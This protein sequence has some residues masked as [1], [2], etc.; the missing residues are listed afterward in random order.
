[1]KVQVENLSPI[2]RKL[3]IEV[4]PSRVEA[5]LDRA[6]QSLSREVKIAGFRPGKVPRRILEQRFRE[7]VEDDVIRR[8]VEGAFLEAIEK[9]EVPAVGAPQVKPA[10]LKPNEP[11]TFEARVEVRP[12]V[13]A[14]DYKGLLL[15][16]RPLEVPDAQVDE[17]L[18]QMR[19]S[20]SR[21]EPVE[22]RQ[23]AQSGDFVVV[24][25]SATVDGT[26]FAGSTGTDVTMEVTQGELIQANVAAL[27]GVKLGEKKVVDYAF[28]ADYRLDEVKGKTARFEFLLKGLKHKVVPALNDELAKEVGGVETLDALR[29][30]VR[31]EIERSVKNKAANETREELFHK[32][33]EKNPLEVPKAM[34][35]DALNFMLEG[36]LRALAR[37][38]LDPRRLGIDFNRLRDEMRPKAELEVKGTLLADSVANAEG[39]QAGDEDFEK[40]LEELAAETGQGLSQVRKAFKDAAQKRSLLARIREEKTI[41]FLKTHAT[42]SKA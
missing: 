11:F 25:F 10:K 37:G 42:Y 32:L 23:V 34:V 17:Q 3:S 41:E 7:Q 13:A 1:M 30:K 16:K 40:K 29:A 15:T 38:G 28:P 2:E 6:Y 27:E 8:V 31:S 22:G 18:E 4:E 14:K 5:E 35:E 19:Q 20:Q 36:A 26:P 24:D 21:L 9:H 12:E 39:I 33:V